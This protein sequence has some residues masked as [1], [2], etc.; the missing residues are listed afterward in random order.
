MCWDTMDDRRKGWTVHTSVLLPTASVMLYCS[1]EHFMTV[2]S[3][4]VSSDK[5]QLARVKM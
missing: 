2:L 5:K 1:V 3:Q 4:M